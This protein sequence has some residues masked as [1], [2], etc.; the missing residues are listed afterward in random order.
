ML[1]GL[2]YFHP[3]AP[4]GARVWV[5]PQIAID[6]G[7]GFDSREYSTYSVGKDEDSETKT[8][9]YL[10][11]GVPYVL[12][13]DENTKFFVRPGFA[14][15]SEPNPSSIDDN[16]TE[17]SISGTLGVEHFFA[18]WFSLGVAHG[19][20]FSS[21]DPG[22]EGSDST[23]EIGTTALGINTVGFHIYPFGRD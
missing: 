22:I 1:I 2:G 4:V 3:S 8:S 9:I 18:D 21:F 17:I 10:D 6:V 23:T 15:S 19:V 16:Q 20:Y 5:N 14:F 12:V 11:A 13:G 7:I